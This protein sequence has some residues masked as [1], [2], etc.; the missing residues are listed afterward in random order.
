MSYFFPVP[1]MVMKKRQM[2]ACAMQRKTMIF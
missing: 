1:V 2:L